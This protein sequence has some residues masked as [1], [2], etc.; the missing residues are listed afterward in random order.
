MVLSARMQ[1]W[2]QVALQSVR[3]LSWKAQGEVS[4]Q[5]M[6]GGRT[7]W[8]ETEGQH[9]RQAGGL[10]QQIKTPH[11]SPC[12]SGIRDNKGWRIGP[13]IEPRACAAGGKFTEA[14]P[15]PQLPRGHLWLSA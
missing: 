1:V 13:E 3:K 10:K 7:S 6:E 15:V 14:M 2:S 11:P 8:F 5:K 12:L 9:Y 4:A